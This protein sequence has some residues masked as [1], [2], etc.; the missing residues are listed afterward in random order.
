MYY[1]YTFKTLIILLC[2]SFLA[3]FEAKYGREAGLGCTDYQE[4]LKL[5]GED[6]WEMGFF[7]SLPTDMSYEEAL[8]LFSQAGEV[9]CLVLALPDKPSSSD[10]NLLL[11]LRLLLL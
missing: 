9:K 5:I 11:L 8:N 3:E 1:L 4:Y 2:F 7:R 10:K 6:P